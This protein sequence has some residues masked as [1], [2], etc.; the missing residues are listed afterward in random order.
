MDQLAGLLE[1]GFVLVVPVVAAG[2]A[3][4]CVRARKLWPG[5]QVPLDAVLF[6]GREVFG[7]NKTLRGLLVVPA[8]CAMA[9]AVEGLCLP[10]TAAVIGP[11]GGF[12]VG[13]AYVLAEL[14]NSFLKRR[15]G[16]PP[17]EQSKRARAVFFLADHLDSALGCG[18]ALRAL[19]EPWSAI[20][21]GMGLA[22]W[23]HVAVNRAAHAVG[24]RRA[25]W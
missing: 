14:P 5:L 11:A 13:L 2:L 9:F 4:Q 7:K 12:A 15:L 20:L 23:V 3:H 17:G 19:G 18:V 24:L 6:G 16:I 21:A 1:R 22:P 25:P 10:R 8:A